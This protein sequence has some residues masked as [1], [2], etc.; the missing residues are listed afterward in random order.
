MSVY[1]TVKRTPRSDVH[2]VAEHVA[3]PRRT[4]QAAAPSP[5]E[6]APPRVVPGNGAWAAFDGAGATHGPKHDVGVAPRP[7]RLLL[8][9]YDNIGDLMLSTP[10]IR[11]LRE[12]MPKARI[13]A[14][15]NSYNS[16]VLER[17]PHVDTASCYGS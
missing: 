11:V 16:P 17:S 9:Q 8:I 15:V 13:D 3:Q 1:R 2:K 5:L 4:E 12:C 6:P 7:L 10:F 14:L